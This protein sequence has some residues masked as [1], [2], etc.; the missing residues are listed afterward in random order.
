MTAPAILFLASMAGLAAT[1]LVPGLA[2][3]SILVAPAALA[4]LILFLRAAVVRGRGAG[5]GRVRP[6]PILVDG[7]NVLYWRGE[8]PEI[9][10]LRAMIAHLTARGYRPGV[11]FDANAGYLIAGRYL[12][13]VP[14]ARMLGLP[15]E[16]VLVVP[17]G[18]PADPVLLR[19]ARDM[20]ARIVTND[21]Y[22]D[23]AEQHPEVTREG[24]L[25]RGALRASGIWLDLGAAEAI[26]QEAREATG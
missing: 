20:G 1:L 3:L 10:T 23:W 15:A 2:D 13:D 18:S 24:F 9:E 5:R 12:D 25:V 4:S 6:E 16:R 22:R 19:V 8:G 11:V 26:P 7:S 21:R 17:K 14:M